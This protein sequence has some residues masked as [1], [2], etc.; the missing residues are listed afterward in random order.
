MPYPYTY[1]DDKEYKA[2]QLKTD[3]SMWKLMILNILTLGIYSI[4]FFIPFS[5]DLDKVAPKSDR[6][7]TMNYLFAFIV[8]YFTFS[9][10]I[11]IWHYQIAE[12]VNEA[13]TER[14]ID[15]EFDT[16]AFWGWYFFGSLILIGPFIYF[17]KLCT[18][19]NL[20]CAHYNENPVINK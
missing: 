18:A 11:L 1:T 14:N 12:R 10:V 15:Y 4:F 5:F 17:H 7:K 16:G 9:V 20:L 2:P 6:S 13:L 8:A 3:R 19:M